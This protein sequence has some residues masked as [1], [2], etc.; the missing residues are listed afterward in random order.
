MAPPRKQRTVLRPLR[1]TRT[2]VISDVHIGNGART[3]WYQ[4]AVHEPYLTALLDWVIAHASDWELPVGKLVI[5]GDFFDFWMYPPDQRP[6]A[7]D[8]IIAANPCI[9]GPGGKLAE[10][11]AALQG[12][13]TYLRGNH[14][15]SLGQEDLDRLPLGGH[16]ITL[17]DDIVV[18]S[19]LVLTHGHLFTMFNAPDPRYPGEQ[20]VGHFV[21]RAIAHLVENTLAPG[22]TAADLAGQGSPYG[23]SLDSFAATL[24]AD[25]TGPSVTSTLLDYFSARC[26]L[27]EDAPIT[28][29]DG[30]T[31][32]LSA[33]RAKYDGLWDDWV[34]RY[35]GG[36]AG[37]T[38]AA[39]AAYADYDGTYLAWFAQQ[40]AWDR[41]A[42]GAVTG[43]THVPRQGITNSTIQYLNCGFE[44]PSAPDMSQAGKTFNFGVIAPDGTPALWVIAG[45]DEGYVVAPVD[46]PPAD[47]VTCALFS[48][49]SCYVSI[50]NATPQ[51]LRKTSETV[52][53]G[54]Y[55]VHPP[56]TIPPG[57]TRHFWLQDLA[58][59]FGAEGGV[60]YTPAEG[61]APLDFAYGCPT[62]YFRNYASGGSSLQASSTSPPDPQQPGNVVPPSGHPLFVDFRVDGEAGSAVG[63]WTPR[64]LLALAVDAAGFRYD[65]LQDIIYS[66]MD[67]LQ[68]KFGYAYGYDAGALAMN[69]IIDC[70]PIFFDYAGKTWMIELWKGQYGLETGCEIGVYNRS[71][72]SSSLFYSVL[73]PTVGNRPGDPNPEHSLF[74]DCAS[75]SELLT[76]SS[77]LY[78]NGQRV[79][80]RGPEPHW[81][82]TGFRWGLLSD[83]GDL[84]MDVTIECLDAVMTSALVGALRNMGYA[85]VDVNGNTV[86]FTFATPK[87]PQPRAA[88]PQLVSI[89][90]A[91]NQEIVGAYDSLGLASNDPNTVG[92]QAA[93]VI[94]NAFAIY[95]EE[96]FASVVAG[97]AQLLGIDASSALRTLTEDFL[98]AL[99]DASQFLT[100][101]G[102]RLAD[103]VD[104]IAGFISEVL[105]FSCVV[106]V[107]NRG[108]P[109]EL[110]LDSSAIVY[111][112][113]AVPPPATIAPGG[114]AR[115]WLKD[116]KPSI[117][118]A[119][120]WVSYSYTDSRGTGQSVR[121]GFDCPTG[122]DPNVATTSSGAFGLYT[123][124]GAVTSAWN[125]LDSV[126]AWGHPLYVTFVWGNAPLPGDV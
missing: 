82:L 22:K 36:E 78:R 23:F 64:S 108:G 113:W 16:R 10:A 53:N 63:N 60:T 32:T 56:D 27:A 100:N 35:G 92:D 98:V 31:T 85:N 1:L 94:A 67:P 61:G 58:G 8:D 41:A 116:P 81:W 46:H 59:I 2:V 101:A 57:E 95:S 103:W 77:V 40:A 47:Q 54:Y 42:L 44:C 50:T 83:P 110:A 99:G 73:D 39:K 12:N 69:A 97:L 29:A 93:A 79:F 74:F 123:K 105:D 114:A 72:G 104:A 21:S 5:L 51:E 120:G 26:G 17:A 4:P 6:P 126:V 90:R 115:F 124:S 13:V 55:V 76:M 19:G 62:A 45:G 48:D 84:T 43:H 109:Y 111:G 88:Y 121:F 38:V 49:F 33:A 89:V 70:E 125:A 66:K 9:L 34:A 7:I 52:D 96:F 87:T 37:E 106:E 107:S 102:Y 68:R 11:V 80:S 15:I 3:C 86:A 28:M 30:S 91:A 14:D 118:G 25:L 112:D 117:H 20:P 122:F 71:I 18:E 75:D 65:P 119:D 24:K